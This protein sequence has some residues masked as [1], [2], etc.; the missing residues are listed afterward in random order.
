MAA[1]IAILIAL[2]STAAQE[3][4]RKPVIAFKTRAAE[5]SVTID[6]AL[7]AHPGLYE[8][9]LAE[10]KR[11]AAKWRADAEAERKVNP[12]DFTNGRYWSLERSYALR[13]AVV[14]RYISIVRSDATFSGGAHPNSF[15]DTLLWDRTARKRISIRPFFK[16]MADEGPTMTALA[17]YARLAV[18]REKIERIKSADATSENANET[19]ESWLAKD[20]WITKSVV[21]KLLGIGPISLAT[22]TI[23]GKSSGLTVH[24]SP[25]AVDAYAAGPYTVFIPWTAFKEFLSAEGVSIFGGERP[26]GDDNW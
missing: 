14:G 24:Y 13:S 2:S 11:D 3:P 16:E 20:D 17:K 25:Y 10:A 22:S 5:V 26:E 1:G 23:A 7:R 4:E 6:N 9:L 12:Q 18:A 19:P 8:N 15:A 21:A